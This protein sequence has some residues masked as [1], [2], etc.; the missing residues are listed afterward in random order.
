MDV[1]DN[2]ETQIDV[3]YYCVADETDYYVTYETDVRDVRRD[4]TDVTTDE[5]DET[6]ETEVSN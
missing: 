4:V 5:T 6:D 3:H 2:T 1:T